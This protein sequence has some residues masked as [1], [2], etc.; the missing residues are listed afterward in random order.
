MLNILLPLIIPCG[1]CNTTIL[2]A[3]LI[4]YK[5]GYTEFAISD[6]P[7]LP[8]KIIGYILCGPGFLFAKYVVIPLH[9]KI[10][11]LISKR[12]KK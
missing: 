2:I 5:K 4:A 8:V 11:T 9:I 12:R 10:K 7:F 1:I 6:E 3:I